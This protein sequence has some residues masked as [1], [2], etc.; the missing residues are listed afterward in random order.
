MNKFDRRYFLKASGVCMALP[1]MPSLVGQTSK[2]SNTSPNRMVF[3]DLS[4]GLEA[5]AFFPKD[6]GKNYTL[7][8]TLSPLKSF[9]NDFT[10]FSNIE[11]IGVTGGHR[12]QHALLSG[13]LLSEAAK[14][15]EGNIT[16]DM[17]AAEH[18]GVKTRYQ[19]LHIG[20]GGS[21]NRMSWTRNGNA[22]PMVNKLDQIFNMLFQD[23][24]AR[25]KSQRQRA[26]N[27]NSSVIDAILEQSKG[28][29]RGLDK[30]DKEKLDEY[31]TS[32]RE[33]EKTL[34]A[35]RNWINKPKPKVQRPRD[36]NGNIYA[37]S[38]KL[39]ALYYDLMFMA[40]KT[41]SSRIISMQFPGGGAPVKLEGV[42]TGYHLLSHHGKD[43]NRLKQLRI[44]EKFHIYQLAKFLQK[45]KDTKEGDTNLLERTQVFMGA[46][47]GNAS[48]HSNRRLPA[49]LAGGG[50]K[51]AGHMK[52][53]KLTELSNLYVTMLQKFG[54][55]VDQFGRSNGK[56]SLS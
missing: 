31:M 5:D 47:M 1:Y 11:H 37:D 41:D 42:D 19:S 56:I 40:L 3:V 20:I 14:F 16:L 18:V 2:K 35:Q 8:P 13:V 15:K 9:K 50:H 39:Y 7:S 46:A 38:D 33:T 36:M 44:I 34:Q 23:D 55:N 6:S 28:I 53:P 22:V 30:E 27:E 29:N 10:V 32:V 48:S 4:L 26:L 43:S 17:K 51:H 21:N 12:A 52:M 54:M 49:I 25:V 45:L 24:T